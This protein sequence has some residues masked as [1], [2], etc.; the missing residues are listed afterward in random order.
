MEN[1][2]MKLMFIGCFSLLIVPI[3]R[4]IC[5]IRIRNYKYKIKNKI[6]N[7]KIFST[8]LEAC[9][10]EQ[11]ELDIIYDEMLKWCQY[12][13][14]LRF[15]IGFIGIGCTVIYLSKQVIQ[16]QLFGNINPLN[17]LIELL[18][19]NK[20]DAKSLSNIQ[21]KMAILSYQEKPLLNM[22][23]IGQILLASFVINDICGN[24]VRPYD[25]YMSIRNSLESYQSKR[26]N[27]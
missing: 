12:K 4:V 5:D 18:K 26:R 13:F 8:D 16:N 20:V 11:E 7:K 19:T 22:Y 9:D 25:E 15:I 6:D 2:I 1:N 24:G 21:E 14:M 17:D 10:K 3:I 27:Y 23:I